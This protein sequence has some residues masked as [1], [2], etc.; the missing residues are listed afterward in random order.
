MKH[1]TSSG[2]LKGHKGVPSKRPSSK[3]LSEARKSSKQFSKGPS[4]QKVVKQ[5]DAG[6][7]KNEDDELIRT[8]R[9]NF[10]GLRSLVT[11]RVCVRLLYEPYTIACGHTFCYSCLSQWFANNKS[12]K[13]CPDCR[14]TVKHQPAPAYL[15]REMTEMFICRAELLPAGETAADHQKWKKEEAEMVERDKVNQDPKNGGLFKGCFKHSGRRGRPIRDDEDGVDR[16]PMCGWELEDGVCT[17]CGLRFDDDGHVHAWGWGEGGFDGFSDIEEGSETGFSSEE[18]DEELGMEDHD[19]ELGFD[20]DDAF[21]AGEDA[22][23]GDE[24]N[25]GY[26][27]EL[28]INAQN[29]AIRRA[30]ANGS[31]RRPAFHSAAGSRRRSYTASL[32]SEMQISEDGEMDTLE[33]ES[34][35]EDGE[36]DSSLSGFIVDDDEEESAHSNRQ[37]SHH[38][39]ISQ[40]AT[41]HAFQNANSVSRGGTPRSEATQVD[42]EYDEVGAVSNGRRRRPA[43][44]RRPLPGSLGRRGAIALSVSTET[45]EDDRDPGEESQ[46]LLRNQMGWAQLDHDPLDDDMAESDDDGMTTVGTPASSLANDRRRLG[47]SLTPTNNRPGPGIRPPSRTRHRP[48]D[49]SRGLRRRSS[50]LSIA[51]TANYEDGEADDDDSEAES[52]SIDRDGD[53]DMDSLST[54]AM[55]HRQAQL[56]LDN[57]IRTTQ[58]NQATQGTSLNDAIDIDTDSTSDASIRPPRRRRNHRTRQPEYNPMISALFAQH[59]SGLRDNNTRQAGVGE[60]Q[61]SSRT[62]T[63]LGRPRSVNRNRLSQHSA[64]PGLAPP[65]SPISNGS[66]PPF[67][68]PSIASGHSRTSSAA[69]MSN[70]NNAMSRSLR[71]PES[72]NMSRSNRSTVTPDGD[73]SRSSTIDPISVGSAHASRSPPSAA[74]IGSPL[75]G[76]SSPASNTGGLRNVG[77]PVGRE[78]ERTNSRAGH[79]TPSDPARRAPFQARE[80]SASPFQGFYPNGPR[81][82]SS[83]GFNIAAQ[84]LQARNPWAP[85]VRPRQSTSRLRE[86]SSTA[87]LRARN[88]RRELRGQPSQVNI[89]DGVPQQSGMRTQASRTSLRSTP[90]HQRLRSQGSV[91]ALRNGSSTPT[92]Q[93]PMLSGGG[94][95][96][97]GPRGSPNAGRSA[98]ETRRLGMEVARR[99]GEE[100]GRRNPFARS[101]S[102]Q[103]TRRLSDS[104]D[105]SQQEQN[106]GFNPAAEFAGGFRNA[107]AEPSAS[108]SSAA[109]PGPNL[110]RRNSRRLMRPTGSGDASVSSASSFAG[111][112]AAVRTRSGQG[113]GNMGGYGN[114]NSTNTSMT[115]GMSPMMATGE[116]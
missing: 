81:V 28:R 2:G 97:A 3:D 103:T 105:V 35:E 108:P 82:P 54:E 99:R 113:L 90:S 42:E 18:L 43:A 102:D 31:I 80:I 14:S 88:S 109:S 41:G 25:D 44:Q 74:D 57:V 6:S 71:R 12:H 7:K 61:E 66:L 10:D 45:D 73:P 33:E 30:I 62:R 116:A 83:P 106:G 107:S 9:S 93:S 59:R 64:S 20:V 114:Q 76:D 87:T 89:R 94:V 52:A 65:F 49:M 79:R 17:Q 91:H 92:A 22:M 78:Y 72:S 111:T 29:Y 70:N 5:V 8:F 38:R 16:C 101:R 23:T 50:V 56:S 53:I 68:P 40:R 98:E 46:A 15:V 96:V 39:T 51:S 60:T 84:S 85:F 110:Q 47:G 24:Y 115:R 4:E 21:Q 11:C 75:Y 55:R 67:S 69:S 104:S 63:P 32:T 86:Q 37:E 58:R 48:L 19:A 36:E 1:S 100:L 112:T 77:S 13:T 27:Q 95:T 34:E 26:D